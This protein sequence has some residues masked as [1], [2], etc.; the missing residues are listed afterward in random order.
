[1]LTMYFFMQNTFIMKNP[2][3]EHRLMNDLAHME[4]EPYYVLLYH[5]V[6]QCNLKPLV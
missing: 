2:L 6:T 4:P 1:M 5:D 3:L